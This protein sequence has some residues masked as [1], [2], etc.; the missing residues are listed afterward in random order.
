MKKLK[1]SMKYV[2]AILMVVL[3]ISCD[4]KYPDLGEGLFA[5]IVTNK[6]TMVAKLHY[7]IA[8]VTVANFVALAEGTHPMVTDSLKGKPFYN[9]LIFHRVMDDFMIQGGDIT[10]TGAGSPGYKFGDELDVSLKHDKPGVLAMANPGANANGSQFY[11]TEKPTPWLDGYDEN[12]NL[13]DCQNPRVYCHSV[14][15]EIVLG[16]EIQDTISNV[17]VGPRDKPVDDVVI[18]AVNIVKQGFSARKFDAVKTWET[19]LPKLEEKARQKEEEAR[20]KASELQRKMDELSAAAASETQPLLEGYKAKS[21]AAA[22]GL[23]THTITNGTGA[24]PKQGQN[25]KVWYEAYFTD[26]K[27]LDTNI[28]EIATKYGQ[29]NEQ[30]EMQ[31]GYSPAPMLI[32]PDANLVAG[33]KEGLA[34]MKVGDKKYFYLPSHLAWGERGSPPVIRPNTDIIFIVE[35]IEI[36]K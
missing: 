25:V 19:E 23:L 36:V 11:I 10:G 2:Y 21:K 8:P 16:L 1:L 29:V 14:F 26:G 31:G 15:G 30:R 24:K 32:S 7:E 12:G 17:N 4:E 9:G 35:M 27:L 34:G 33:F 18:E 6:G 22:S 28:K 13:K 5:E 3:L 20:Q